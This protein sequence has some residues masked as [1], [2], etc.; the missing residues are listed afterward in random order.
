MYQFKSQLGFVTPADVT[1]IVFRYEHLDCLTSSKTTYQTNVV[2]MSDLLLHW[3]H[4]AY[5]S[6]ICTQVFHL[7]EQ[8]KPTT[9]R[10]LVTGPHLQAPHTYQVPRI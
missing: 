3:F 7:H 6:S 10:L 9:R 8:R 1:C 5:S 2:P 4:N